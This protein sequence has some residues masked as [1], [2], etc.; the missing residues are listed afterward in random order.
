MLMFA[1][2]IIHAPS[3]Q[4][5]DGRWHS[6]DMSEAYQLIW[7]L[8]LFLQGKR[9]MPKAAIKKNTMMLSEPVSLVR[10]W[11]STTLIWR[12][13]EVLLNF[14]STDMY[15]C[16]YFI[17]S[18]SGVSKCQDTVV[19]VSRCPVEKTARS[20]IRP[21][22]RPTAN[23]ANLHSQRVKGLNETPKLVKLHSCPNNT[24]NNCIE[25]S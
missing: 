5:K 21:Q 2:Q 11:G 14:S 12:T 15:S 3:R 9:G 23:I 19:T 20:A 18:M 25:I 6:K 13:A 17:I 10:W 16:L 22:C 8:V 1:T 4:R 7:L 24:S